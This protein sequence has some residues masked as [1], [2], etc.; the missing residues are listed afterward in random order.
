MSRTSISI[1]QTTKDRLDSLKRDD[2]T[3]DEFLTRLAAEEEPIESGVLSR[4]EGERIKRQI[5][6]G[7]ERGR[8]YD[9]G[10]E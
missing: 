1:Q 4:E 2:E 10:D 7:R 5:R 9:W 8:S 6:E 3:W